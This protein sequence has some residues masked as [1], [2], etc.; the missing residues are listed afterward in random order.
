MKHTL[1]C[2]LPI[3]NLCQLIKSIYSLGLL[4]EKKV[5]EKTVGRSSFQV[6]FFFTLMSLPLLKKLT[7]NFNCD[8]GAEENKFSRARGEGQQTLILY[9]NHNLATTIRMY[10]NLVG[11]AEMI[12]TVDIYIYNFIPEIRRKGD[13]RQCSF[14]VGLVD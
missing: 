2:I 1:E 5:K 7:A 14:F 4:K 12:K 6:F 8:Y 13:L 10:T 3:L 11:K 9:T